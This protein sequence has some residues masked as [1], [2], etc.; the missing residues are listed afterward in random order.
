AGELDQQLVRLL[1]GERRRARFLPDVA[2]LG[3]RP[4]A[5]QGAGRNEPV[6]EDRVRPRD[7][8]ERATGHEPG[9]PRAGTNE[10]HDAAHPRNAIGAARPP[11]RYPAA[12]ARSASSSSSAAPAARIRSATLSP[13]LAGSSAG[14]SSSSR[15]H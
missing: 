8:L 12:T 11:N 4:R 9:V 7:Q 13:T 3:V 2:Q 5:L 6:V 1:L 10:I 14:P 15:I